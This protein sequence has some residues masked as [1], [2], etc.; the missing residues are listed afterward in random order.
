M[1][2]RI[3]QQLNQLINAYLKGYL[4]NDFD[5]KGEISNILYQKGNGPDI[6][7]KIRLI[8][9]TIPVLLKLRN[10]TDKKVNDLNELLT[11]L[12][13]SIHD[14]VY[15]IFVHET[16]IEL[17]DENDHAIYNFFAAKDNHGNDKSRKENLALLINALQKAHD[18]I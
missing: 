11:A 10:I 1:N 12:R 9:Q 17:T 16:K 15:D 8:A 2:E 5:F 13:F 7:D 3:T 14:H 6:D 18:E 4:E